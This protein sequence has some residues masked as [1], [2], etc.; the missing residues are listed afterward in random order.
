[1]KIEDFF[2]KTKNELNNDIN[3]YVCGPTTYDYVHIGNIRPAMVFDV[4]N[5]LISLDGKFNYVHNLTDIDDKII[6][7]AKKENVSEREIASFYSK[8]YIENLAE[9]NIKAPTFMPT[10][11]KN[12]DGMIGFVEELIQKGYAYEKNGDVY[13]S[14]NKW[15]EYGKIYNL[16]LDALLNN[17]AS[18]Q[19]KY[20]H[21]FALWKKTSDGEKFL[22]PW[23]KGRPGWHTE[24]SFFVQKYFGKK[25]IDI[26]GG[27]VDLKFPHH[28]NEMAQYES[29]NSIKMADNWVYVG[30]VNF[31]NEKMSKSIGNTFTVEE[32]VNKYS[33]NI[34]RYLLISN[35]YTKPINL[36]DDL[37]ENTINSIDKINNSLIKFLFFEMSNQRDIKIKPLFDEK[38]KNI[39]E[40]DL[41]IP[42]ALSY[43]FSQLKEL[44]KYQDILVFYKIIFN[45]E[46]LGFKL[47]FKFNFATII[48]ALREHDYTIIDSERK[49]RII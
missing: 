16:N 26:H 39:L 30:H 27:G 29:L 2:S 7:R 9:L 10:V 8:K 13:F 14:V 11:S 45:L 46:L 23:S 32:F 34:L 33:A 31:N 40:D 28:I 5:R 1:M 15:E 48:K 47:N 24:C 41:D 44:N 12:I 38:F 19:K 22:S 6:D 35:H 20:K 42:N 4:L 21:D 36:S 43:I 37:I 49:R 25:G 17:D 18:K 3:V